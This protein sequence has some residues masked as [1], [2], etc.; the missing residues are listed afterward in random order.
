MIFLL[1][2]LIIIKLILIQLF[3]GMVKKL[4]LMV[5]LDKLVS[6]KVMINM[7]WWPLIFMLKKLF[8]KLELNIK[9]KQIKLLMEKFKFTTNLMMDKL[10]FF[11]SCLKLMI[12]W[13]MMKKTIS[14]KI[15][16]LIK[17]SLICGN[18]VKIGQWLMMKNLT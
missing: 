13:M 8:S 6:L 9:F 12:L 4:K 7:K 5:N 3:H 1:N 16:F 11:L 15:N 14:K 18:T 2:L 10:L 17:F